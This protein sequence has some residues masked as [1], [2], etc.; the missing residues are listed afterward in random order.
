LV[1]GAISADGSQIAA[2]VGESS[3]YD[4]PAPQ[5]QIVV[6]DAERGGET[7]VLKGHTREIEQIHF[8]GPDELWS[9][10]DDQTLRRWNLRLQSQVK[11]VELTASASGPELREARFLPGGDSIALY[12]SKYSKPDHY[13]MKIVVLDTASGALRWEKSFDGQWNCR[14][15]TSQDGRL[16][17]VGLSPAPV[18]AAKRSILVLSAADGRELLRIEP[19][20]GM[21]SSLTFSADGTK[22]VSG[23]SAGDALVWDVSAA[24]PKDK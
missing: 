12:D 10:S 19:E 20:D 2:G 6:W 15:A 17:A 8:A 22:L 5:Y 18:G 16:L 9:L 23:M 24:Q 11:R 1:C 7:A 21:T 13:D 14:L 4:R 3:N